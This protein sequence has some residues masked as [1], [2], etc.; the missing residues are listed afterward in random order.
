LAGLHQEHRGRAGAAIAKEA[1]MSKVTTA[2]RSAL[3]T[4]ILFA[5][6]AILSSPAV[7]A[8]LVVTAYGGIWEKALRECYV[9][10][11]E[12]QTGKT[13]EV[14]LGSSP[15]WMNQVEANQAKPPIHVMMNGI[16]GALLAGEKGLV[17]KFTLERVPNLASVPQKFRDIVNNY[18]SV[19]NYG[20]A[21]LAFNKE[22]VKAPPKT[23]KEFIDRTI[24]GEWTASLPTINYTDSLSI[25][26]WNM[27]DVMGGD[28]TNVTPGFD[29]IKKL[30]ASGHV[31]WWSSVT[32]FLTQMQSREAD[33]GIYWDGR[34]WAFHDDNKPWVDFVNPAPGGVAVPNIIQKVKNAPD[35][36]WRFVDIALSPG[37]QQCFTE[38]L[39]YPVVNDKV[40]YP[41]KL[42]PRIAKLDEIRFPPADVVQRNSASWVERW[43]KE[44]GR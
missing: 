24:A 13:V 25:L 38:R 41:E 39:Q 29:A 15:Q 1:V 28:A 30:K 19:I 9:T 11:F 43:N 35:L 44:I 31:I 4:A 40:V 23:W 20:A 32:E 3:S 27:A 17:D 6:G 34:T 7:A 14:V 37:P 16:A 22:Q 33:I 5:L 10:A 18:G 42:R 26:I 2:G 12:K 8:D 36:A 21:G